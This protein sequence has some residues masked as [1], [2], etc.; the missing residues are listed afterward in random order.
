MILLRTLQTKK[1]VKPSSTGKKMKTQ[2][3]NSNI[4][5]LPQNIIE[6]ILTLMPIRDALRTSILSKKWR[7]IWRSMPKLVFTQDMVELPLPSGY[8]YGQLKNYKLVNAIFHVLLLHNGPTILEFNFD[9]GK[10]QMVSEFDQILSYLSKG[11]GVKELILV[12]GRYNLPVSFFSLQGLERIQLRDCGFQPPLTFKGF[13][14]L[15]SMMLMNCEVS[16]RRLQWFLSKCRLIEHFHLSGYQQLIHFL[17]GQSKFTFVDLLWCVP[18]IQDLNISEYYMK[19]M[20]DDEKLPVQQTPPNFLDLEDHSDLKLD[21]LETL[22]IERF[23]DLPLEREFAKLVMAKSPVLKKVRIELHDKV[24]IDE[25]LKM[26][27][28]NEFQ[29]ASISECGWLNKQILVNAVFHVLFLHNGPTILEFNWSL[30]HFDISSELDQIISRLAMQNTTVK[31]LIIVINN[32]EY[33]LPVAFCSVQGLEHIHLENCS[34]KPDGLTFDGFSR[35]RKVHFYEVEIFPEMLHAFLSKCPLLEDVCLN[36]QVGIDFAPGRSKFTFVDLFKCIPFVETLDISKDYMKYLCAENMPRKLPTSL[37]DLKYLFL[38]VCLMEHREISSVLC[39]MRS[40]P[41][42]AEINIVLRCFNGSFS[43]ARCLRK[44]VCS[45]EPKENSKNKKMNAESL[46]SDIISTLPPNIIENILTLMPIRDA[47]RTSI[48]SKKWRCSNFDWGEAKKYKLVSAIFHVLLLHN[49]P[50]I[51]ELDTSVLQL[52]IDSDFPQIISYLARGNKVKE[53]AFVNYKILRFCKLPV[54]FFSLQ[55]LEIIHLKNCTF[56]PPPTFEGFSRLK[57]M[58]FSD[59]NVSA[60]MLKR[61]ISKCP[62]LE[63][64]S[65]ADNEGN[66]EFVEGGKKVTFVDLFQCVPLILF[67]DISEFYMKVA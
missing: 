51:L 38:D 16:A 40:S 28:D 29:W 43:N 20:Y 2:C 64:I 24:S 56:E 9:V 6:T 30:A 25:E 35:L 48:L 7:Y 31:E 18:L 63:E 49:G 15:K 65:L 32:G 23:S 19:V 17:A 58:K 5:T 33:R 53:L 42:L 46:S 1:N 45:A 27:R 36:G 60:Q 34:F 41:L 26:L 57:S 47:L 22:V 50:T 62:L 61:F 39:M 59:C 44:S 11:N 14:W 4:T 66:Y 12:I 52:D 10:H 67:L 13:R 54:S 21:N 55:G 37:D 3:L 8:G